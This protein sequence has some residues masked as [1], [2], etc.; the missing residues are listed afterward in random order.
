MSAFRVV[1]F[2]MQF[3]QVWNDD[4]PDGAPVNLFETCREI[5]RHN[6]DIILLQEVEHVGPDGMRPASQPNYQRLQSAL[7]GYDSVL[8]FPRPDPRELPFGTGLAI[9]SRTALHDFER[10]E[11]PS[12]PIPFTFGGGERTPTDRLM[13]GV[14][15]Q[16]AGRRLRL[17]NTHLLAFFMLNSS[18]ELHPGQR[19][20]VVEILRQAPEPALIGGDFNVS[21]HAPLVEQMGE[22]GFAPV[23]ATVPT[24]RRRP[25]VLDH[26]FLGRGLRCVS[27]AVVETQ[28]SDH[29]VLVADLEFA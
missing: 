11:L 28:A 25:Y 20:R 22:A 16:V 17:F 10:H 21:R 4:D 24:W 26:I 5:R 29:H 14:T 18:S 12:P 13:I 1:Q 23:Q 7:K 6:A 15:T 27:H 2:N 8:A 19:R 3:G 9:F